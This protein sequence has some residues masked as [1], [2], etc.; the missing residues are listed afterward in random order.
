MT[1]L[2][3][4]DPQAPL[5]AI[6]GLV[7]DRSRQIAAALVL[8]R[9]N[10]VTGRT[11]TETAIETEQAWVEARL[12]VAGRHLSPGIVAGLRVGAAD[13]SAEPGAFVLSAGRGIAAGG[14]D[15]A[16]LKPAR[17]RLDDLPELGTAGEGGGGPRGLIAL[18]LEPVV[19]EAERLPQGS[20]SAFVDP[21]PPDATTA[22]YLD[23]VLQDGARVAWVALDA[24]LGGTDAARMPN[25]AAEALRRIEAEA[26][27]LMPW[28]AL[29][30]PLC[31]M[32]VADDGTILWVHRAG[33]ARRGGL[34]PCG[35]WGTGNALRQSRL[36]GLVEETE[37]ATRLAG[38][39]GANGAAFMR[40]LPPAGLLPRKCWDRPDFFPGGWAVAQAPI[41]LS[42]LDAALEATARLAPFDLDRPRDRVKFLV[43]VPDEHY[44]ADLLE[45]VT[46]PDFDA[47]RQPLQARVGD[48]L[49]LRNAY[50]AQAR[51][52]QG[53]IDH[54]AITDFTQ[55]EEDPIAG[56]TGFPAAA[57]APDPYAQEARTALQAVFDGLDPVLFTEGQLA[58]VDP[59]SLDGVLDPQT[60]FG[61]TPFVVTMRG[62]LD[63][64]NDTIDFAFNRVQAEIYRLRQIM[65]D[66][67]EATKL[68]TFPTLAGLAK[69]SNAYATAEGLRTHF[70]ARRQGATVGDGTAASVGSATFATLSRVPET[71]PAGMVMMT[72]VNL[73]LAGAGAAMEAAPGLPMAR[74]AGTALA[75]AAGTFDLRASTALTGFGQGSETFTFG[76]LFADAS[77]AEGAGTNDVK[78]LVDS[79]RAG[80]VDDALL[81]GTQA[82]RSGILRSAPLPGDFRDVRSAT[83]AD[84]LKVPASVNA[85]AA[86]VRIKADVLR[87]LQAMGLS[88]EGIRAPLTSARDRVILPRADI[89]RVIAATLTPNEQTEF[90]EEIGRLRAGVGGTDWEMVGVPAAQSSVGDTVTLAPMTRL[91]TALLRETG[92]ITLDLLPALTL[93][94]QLDPDP[95]K[96]SGG[97]DPDDESAYLSAAVT[98]LENAIAIIRAVEGRVLAIANAVEAAAAALPGLKK[99]EARWSG[100]LGLA[101]QDLDEARHDLR[102]AISLIDEE[103]ARLARLAAHRQRVLA[104]KVTFVAFTRPRALTA[105]RHGDT[106]GQMLPGR[107]EDPLPASLARDVRLPDDL[108]AMVGTLREMPLGW[109]ASDPELVACFDRPDFLAHLF[110]GVKA[111]AASKAVRVAPPTPKAAPGAGQALR[112]IGEVSDAYHALAMKLFNAR[113]ALDLASVEK[114]SW[115]A[116]RRRALEL[117]SLN[118]L[119]ESGRQPAVARKAAAEIEQIERVLHALWQMARQVPAPIRLLWAQALSAYDT[120][121]RLDSLAGLPGWAFVGFALRQQMERLN[122]WLFGRME[123]GIGEAGALMTDVVRVALLLAAHAPVAD[124]VAARIEAPQTAKPG[125]AVDIVIRRGTPSIGMSVTF[126][127]ANMVQA[128]GVV[129]DLYG[130]R[131]R[132]EIVEAVQPAITLTAAQQVTLFA[133]QSLALTGGR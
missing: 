22:P 127:D 49:A 122:V 18:V 124:I 123:P 99:L 41:P 42:Q 23:F 80:L 11:L 77:K 44:A 59:G 8:Q 121:T 6:V 29:G 95:G 96:G 63:G 114:E 37:M 16:M 7:P 76:A 62:L 129:R 3:L 50:R 106:L 60:G 125:S 56:E 103:T 31:L 91:G 1:A 79:T 101:D 111:R 32:S 118:D 69:G 98:T 82:K 74:G 51:S 65:L 39:S 107:F 72:S 70:L 9:L 40:W 35:G 117:L 133:P 15:V 4:P 67:E 90:A 34:L 78:A 14:Q 113:A 28:A 110:R 53:V 36:E 20:R 45:P 85:K 130:S 94:K 126:L 48:K 46:P 38:W 132:V 64:A 115:S 88:L 19:V 25:F 5:T 55:A 10:Y 71:Q 108:D 47:V 57:P 2:T 104:E 66:G 89:D 112:K 12:G 120:V 27:H 92:P 100:A 33:A 13:Q 17:L 109:F 61:L 73:N 26:P 97:D 75:G 87:Q 81:A 86:A 131:A 93:S 102:V 43:P 128:R 24:A 83:I 54:L 105:H 30:V 84:R 116:R 21:C 68:A 119:I 52:V 58:M